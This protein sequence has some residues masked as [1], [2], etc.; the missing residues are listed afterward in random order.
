MKEISHRP[1]PQ[2]AT[3]WRSQTLERLLLHNLRPQVRH[4]LDPL[5]FVYWERVGVEDAIVYMLHHFWTS[6]ASSNHPASALKGQTDRNGGRLTPGG[7]DHGLF[8]RQ[9]SIFET[10]GLQVRHCGQQHGS[11]T[12]DR[13]LSSPVHPIQCQTSSIT[14]SPVTGEEERAGQSYIC[15]RATGAEKA[16]VDHGRSTG[17]HWVLPHTM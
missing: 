5:Q 17:F 15:G 3:S 4:T 13:A 9:T 16:P 7:M 8:D 14:R 12:G 1:S 11:A 6:P 2:E 10:E